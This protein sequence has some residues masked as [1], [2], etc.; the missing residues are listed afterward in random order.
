VL[1]VTFSPNG[2]LVVT[3]SQDGTAKVWTTMTGQLLRTFDPQAAP[4]YSIACS[5]DGR[6]VLTGHDDAT[7]RLWSVAGLGERLEIALD[8]SRAELR[9]SLGVL[10][11]AETP[12]GPWQDL[13]GATSPY[14]VELL[15]AQRFYR[16]KIAE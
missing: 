3:G 12:A 5:P 9:W 2:E 8:G 11:E 16:L 7:A 6:Y 10:Q 13:L 15:E 4:V 14:Q 1:A